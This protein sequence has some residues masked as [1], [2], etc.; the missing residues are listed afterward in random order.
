ML[1]NLKKLIL[2]RGIKDK[3]DIYPTKK[4]GIYAVGTGT[5]VGELWLWI[6]STPEEHLFFSIPKNVNRR[7]PIDKFEWAMKHKVMEFVEL[8]PKDVYA[9]CEAQW[10]HNEK[11]KPID[12][13]V[14]L[15]K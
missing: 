9:L 10:K 2:N 5:Y 3:R 1:S 14:D 15:T 11:N 8:L 13:P 4:R 7:A 12:K 6:K